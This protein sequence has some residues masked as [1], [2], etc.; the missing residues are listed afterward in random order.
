MTTTWCRPSP[1]L[2]GFAV[3]PER[4]KKSRAMGLAE[5]PIVNV[6]VGTAGHIDHGK[7]ELVKLLTGCDT[8]TLAEEKSRGMSIDLGFAPCTLQ[9]NLGV[10]IVDVPGHEKF[11]KNMVAGAT[12]IDVLLLVVA[13][14]DGVMPQTREHLDIVDLLGIRQGMVAI[15][16]IDLVDDE[17]VEL[18]AEEARE[19]LK[20]TS[21]EGSPIVP[22]SSIT[23][24]GYDRFW[25]TL[26]E[27][28]HTAR[29]KNVEGPFRFP[30]ERVFSVK[31]Y[32]AVVTGIP[33][34]GKVR[35]DE[36]LE[37]FPQRRKIR[38]RGLQVF[39]RTEEQGLAGQCIA[40]SLAG[41]SHDE[42]E[43]GSVLATPRVF[44]PSSAPVARLRILA[45]APRPLRHRASVRFLTGTS[46]VKASVVVLEGERLAPGQEGLVQ[47]LLE[48][49]LVLAPGDPYVIRFASPAVTVGGGVVLRPEPER[50]RR[51]RE[52]TI[53][54]LKRWEQALGDPQRM[55]EECLL[56]S[57]PIPTDARQ[58]AGVAGLSVEQ[59]SSALEALRKAGTA[60]AVP[61][62][63]G[64]FVHRSAVDEAAERI[65][66]G[67]K[68][69]HVAHPHVRGMNMAALRSGTGLR[70]DVVD[71]AMKQLAAASRVKIEGATAR[72]ATHEPRLE[73]EESGL[74]ARIE[75]L[76]RR[77]TFSTPRPA[78]AAEILHA[79][80]KAAQRVMEHLVD[81]RVLARLGPGLYMHREA[82]EEGERILREYI[83]EHGELDSYY[84]K[85][86]IGSTRRYALGLLD[87]YDAKGITI[88]HGNVR[89]LKS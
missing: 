27:V 2:G 11:I 46:Q 85:T 81:Q 1:S 74:A 70:P 24:K 36:E 82:V 48:E 6:M 55:A 67:L 41:V 63:S 57:G 77:K 23:G 69:F 20:G 30:V 26:S 40:A 39:G 83:R 12:G 18:A 29:R 43:R 49:S 25:A 75:A 7:T 80:E 9:D 50:V 16:K 76:Y 10:G 84:F 87:Y 71:L 66:R 89:R 51:K 15:T 72:L 32:G 33:L 4:V 73:D 58:V 68:D 53:T 62:T 17:T 44:E 37:L 64:A 3:S 61:G 86:L 60:V 79:D 28:V 78:E 31:G 54:P 35:V 65:V 52:A 42:M 21:L 8:D 88:R 13:A 56:T 45:A 14:D 38:V 47:F 59:A 5:V 22:V 34:S 19:L